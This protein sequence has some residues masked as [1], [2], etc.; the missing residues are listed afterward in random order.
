MIC[1]TD[2]VNNVNCNRVRSER[3]QRLRELL[4]ETKIDDIRFDEIAS[5]SFG[6]SRPEKSRGRHFKSPLLLRQ[7]CTQRI[8]HT[9][10]IHIHIHIHIQIHIRA[11]VRTHR[12]AYTRT[13]A[14]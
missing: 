4:G 8:Q 2:L 7:H 6:S 9:R 10:A 12:C 3:K 11:H 14:S 1:F 13:F 5:M